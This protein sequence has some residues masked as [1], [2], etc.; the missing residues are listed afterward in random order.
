M[1]M[2]LTI[3]ETSNSYNLGNISS[4]YVAG[5]ISYTGKSTNCYNK[6]NVKGKGITAGIVPNAAAENCYNLGEITGNTSGTALVS[7]IASS[8]KNCYNSGNV[9][10]GSWP[11]AGITPIYGATNCYNTGNITATDLSII[12]E[13]SMGT[14]TNC[15][16]LTKET[17]AQANGAV[18]KTEAE[19]KEIMDLQKF[20]DLMNQKVEE[21]N[22]NAS[23][24]KWKKWKLANGV[25][26]FAE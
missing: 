8:A 17:N 9:N 24:T 12:Y 2:E 3:G 5:G 16:Y 23:N 11:T 20:V 6:G 13:I 22:S 1:F 10:G 18:G 21:N 4:E 25:P 7:G 14:S 19:M 15:A 26:V